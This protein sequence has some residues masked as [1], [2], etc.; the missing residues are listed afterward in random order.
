M[1]KSFFR[2][3]RDN[4]KAELNNVPDLTEKQWEE[5]L[6]CAR[7]PQATYGKSRALVQNNLVKKGLA[8][9]F[10]EPPCN[11]EVCRATEAGRD[12]LRRAGVKLP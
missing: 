11:W 6:R 7:T 4:K 1:K 12:A 9:K 5:L 8:E 3:V 10:D 2:I